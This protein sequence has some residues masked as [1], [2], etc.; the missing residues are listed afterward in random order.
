MQAVAKRMR[1]ADSGSA[2]SGPGFLGFAIGAIGGTAIAVAG[3]G[4]DEALE[5]GAVFAEGVMS[6]QPPVGS[7]GGGFEPGGP[8]PGGFSST[9]GNPG[10]TASGGS[11]LIPNFPDTSDVDNL[12]LSW[13]PAS[14]D[15]QR[16]AF[17]LQAAAIQCSVSMVP[18]PTPEIISRAQSQITEVCR[19]LEG[20][21]RMTVGDAAANC[22]CPDSF[23]Q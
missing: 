14:V 5:A 21:D 22:R 2:D 20:L 23:G 15:I 8:A 12:G 9:S 7:S 10:T 19:R 18:D 17:A 11:C 16:R 4:S 1:E 13:C 3:G 6:G